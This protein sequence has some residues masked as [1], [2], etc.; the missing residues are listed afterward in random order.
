MLKDGVKRSGDS[1]NL[2]FG[3]TLFSKAVERG[4]YEDR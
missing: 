3:F 4:I 1:R 2:C